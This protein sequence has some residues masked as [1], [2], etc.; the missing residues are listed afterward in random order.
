MKKSVEKI[1]A[2]TDTGDN[3]AN[4]PDMQFFSN[5]EEENE[6][7]AYLSAQ[8]SPEESLMKAHKLIMQIYGKDYQYSDHAYHNITFVII[9]GIPC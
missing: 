2:E 5:F 4:N 3:P 7:T 8:L 1:K 9:K 6:A